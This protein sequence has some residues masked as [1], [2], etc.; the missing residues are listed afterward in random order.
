MFAKIVEMAYE[1][2][3]SWLIRDSGSKCIE[4]HESRKKN[5]QKVLQHMQ[6]RH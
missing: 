5:V 1:E 3:D 6:L 2:V 4:R